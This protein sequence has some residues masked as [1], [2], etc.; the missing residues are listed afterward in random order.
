MDA[1]QV[2]SFSS[3]RAAGCKIPV[4]VSVDEAYLTVACPD[5]GGCND[6]C[7]AISLFLHHL[8]TPQQDIVGP[9]VAASHTEPVQALEFCSGVQPLLLCS[10]SYSST[11]LWEVDSIFGEGE[12]SPWQQQPQCTSLGIAQLP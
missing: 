4:A 6:G 2:W 3:G 12:L 7:Y 9:G 11:L 10:A 5:G 1:E 8:T